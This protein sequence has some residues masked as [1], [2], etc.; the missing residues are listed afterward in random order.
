MRSE[1]IETAIFD[2]VKT[3]HVYLSSKIYKRDSSFNEVD[4]HN[5]FERYCYQSPD[6]LSNS[7]R[8]HLNVLKERL[9]EFVRN[10]LDEL[11]ESYY[12]DIKDRIEELFF[13][14]IE[15]GFLKSNHVNFKELSKSELSEALEYFHVLV[16]DKDYVQL[17]DSEDLIMRDRLDQNT[18]NN[19]LF[20]E[21]S[22]FSFLSVRDF[23][24]SSIIIDNHLR[25]IDMITNGDIPLYNG[26]LIDINEKIDIHSMNNQQE[27]FQNDIEIPM[28]N[29]DID[30]S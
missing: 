8:D 29:D 26:I 27:E 23:N 2:Y 14:N 15:K 25:A 17:R 4:Q 24:N 21:L 28:Q 30:I 6:V 16:T 3:H 12:L 13:E 10:S 5:I 20:K 18:L 19:E 9:H 7:F 22:D 11:N 1:F